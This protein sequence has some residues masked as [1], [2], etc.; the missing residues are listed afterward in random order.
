L[1]ALTVAAV[2]SEAERVESLRSYKILDTL[3]DPAF[4]DIAW[5]AARFCEAPIAMISLIDTD[6]I[7]FKAKVGTDA[8]SVPRAGSFCELTMQNKALTVICDAASDPRFAAHPLV[9]DTARFDAGAPLLM[10]DGHVIGTLC[11]LD[12]QPRDLSD[13]QRLALQALAR[14]VVSLLTY[15]QQ[16]VRDPLTGLF[17]RR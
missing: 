16:S 6:R 13:P 8:D 15:R 5:M 11:V 14:Q 12:R 9:P 7:W 1:S 17:N 2:K 4:D 10:P 3:L